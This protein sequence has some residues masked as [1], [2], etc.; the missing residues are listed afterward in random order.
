MVFLKSVGLNILDR[1]VN[2]TA[3]FIFKKVT[4]RLLKPSKRLNLLSMADSDKGKSF[5]Y[6]KIWVTF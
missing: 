4:D 3:K 5:G 6:S 2:F 1:L